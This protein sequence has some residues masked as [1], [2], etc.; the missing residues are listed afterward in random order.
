MSDERWEVYGTGARKARNVIFFVGDG[1]MAN[2]TAA[3]IPSKG[4]KRGGHFGK[5]AFDD[6]PHGARRHQRRGIRSSPT[7][8]TR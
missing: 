8:P 4:I 3:R 5:L 2:R 6:M 7:P 1:M